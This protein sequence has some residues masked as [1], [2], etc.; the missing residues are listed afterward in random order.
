LVSQ[1]SA[2]SRYERATASNDSD[3]FDG[4]RR[5]WLCVEVEGLRAELRSWRA[6][7]VVSSP[8]SL[9][10]ILS[11]FKQSINRVE[12]N[13]LFRS[14]LFD[15]SDQLLEHIKMIMHSPKRRLIRERKMLRPHLLRNMDASCRRWYARQPGLTPIE[16]AG[17]K[18]R[19]KGVVRTLSTDTTENRLT[20]LLLQR[21]QPMLHTLKSSTDQYDP[22]AFLSSRALSR[23]LNQWMN[24]RDFNELRAVEPLQPTFALLKDIHYH[25]VWRVWLWFKRDQERADE[26]WR[27]LDHSAAELSLLASMTAL[28]DQGW[29]LL[30]RIECISAFT[31]RNRQHVQVDVTDSCLVRPMG[32]SIA[33]LT[34]TAGTVP[35]TIHTR[36]LSNQLPKVSLSIQLSFTQNTLRS[37][38]CSNIVYQFDEGRLTD[39]LKRVSE[40]ITQ[41]LASI[42]L[43]PSL[44]VNVLTDAPVRWVAASAVDHCSLLGNL[45]SDH[46][47]VNLP[48]RLGL[49][50][51]EELDP[52]YRVDQ[53]TAS[54]PVC[55]KV[56]QWDLL[57]SEGRDTDEAARFLIGAPNFTTLE[58]KER[59]YVVPDTLGPRAQSALYDVANEQSKPWLIPRSIAALLSLDEWSEGVLVKPNIQSG[60]EWSLILCLGGPRATLSIVRPCLYE[61]EQSTEP[62]IYWE[63]VRS[64]RELTWSLSDLVCEL[65]MITTD[66]ERSLAWAMNSLS[67]EDQILALPKNSTMLNSEQVQVTIQKS[68]DELTLTL[69]EQIRS[70]APPGALHD[71]HAVIL[72]DTLWIEGVPSALHMVN[73]SLQDVLKDQSNIRKIR[74][75][76]TSPAMGAESFLIRSSK[77]KYTWFDYLP[78]VDI[79]VNKDKVKEWKTII[80]PDSRV[81]PQEP[82][83]IQDVT[84]LQIKKCGPKTVV[85]LRARI[86]GEVV[87]YAALWLLERGSR[88]DEGIKIRAGWSVGGAELEL[89][90]APIEKDSDILQQRFSWRQLTESGDV[91]A[92][93]IWPHLALSSWELSDQHQ[94][95]EEWEQ[96]KSLV[97]QKQLD[98]HHLKNLIKSIAGNFPSKMKMIEET[99]VT[100]QTAISLQEQVT[101]MARVYQLEVG[102]KKKISKA[103]KKERQRW[104]SVIN[105]LDTTHQSLYK[106]RSALMRRSALSLSDILK[107]RGGKSEVITSE[108]LLV[109]G[110]ALR[111]LN[112]CEKAEELL[113]FVFE[114]AEINIKSPDEKIR[115]VCSV[116][117]E[118]LL[119]GN[120]SIWLNDELNEQITRYLIASGDALVE[121]GSKSDAWVELIAAFYGLLR[122]REGRE[123]SRGPKSDWSTMCTAKIMSW[124]DQV[125]ESVKKRNRTLSIGED[126]NPWDGLIGLFKGVQEVHLSA[127]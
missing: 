74:V 30:D 108:Q 15:V 12:S 67:T 116:L 96:L 80:Q 50:S 34:I 23:L 76:D 16:K 90:C 41:R 126:L 48:Y 77:S 100:E 37:P 19:L 25:P 121:R 85:N 68:V 2:P 57:L 75:L 53:L 106:W 4:A 31:T 72:W 8:A 47:I 78:Q 70:V 98:P 102:D 101:F 117:A 10:L 63:R 110:A 104:K 92:K 64:S 7:D 61:D 27:T 120:I 119:C 22:E 118:G 3:H 5:W 40:E 59:A 123:E 114:R 9:S 51:G 36:T 46:Q 52:I 13:G 82:L 29:S 73:N 105:A 81:G 115:E 60:H 14:E 86:D 11:R 103:E 66:D 28:I 17:R 6:T 65:A 83:I 54:D 44:G 124:S 18:Q 42:C 109:L 79:E 55:G 32:N 21:L 20:M 112:T 111:R 87:P 45:V 33:Y 56:G 43:P 58:Y 26:L 91:Q 1:Q 113:N 69:L 93:N 127:F 71:D 49:E 35:Q 97:G 39:N 84:D 38:L 89:M 125:D 88:R 99:S 94:L 24:N 107:R 122:G 62:Y 95:L